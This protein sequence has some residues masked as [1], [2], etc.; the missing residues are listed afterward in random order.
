MLIRGVGT[1]WRFCGINVYVYTSCFRQ[2]ASVVMLAQM[3][4]VPLH[5]FLHFQPQ[6]TMPRQ[7]LEVVREPQATLTVPA[8]PL[9]QL[10]PL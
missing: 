6:P 2:A 4:R 3:D 10:H 8:Q 7:A 5:S 1:C 9:V